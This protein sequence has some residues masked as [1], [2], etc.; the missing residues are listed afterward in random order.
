MENK[1]ISEAGKWLIGVVLAYIVT[2]LLDLIPFGKMFEQTKWEWIVEDRFNIIE[3]IIFTL[4]LI[5]IILVL[6]RIKPAKSKED[7]IEEKLKAHKDFEDPDLG[8]KVTWDM[9]MGSFYDNDPHP[10]N[11]KTYCTKHPMPLLMEYGRCMDNRCPNANANFNERQ[12][13]QFIQSYLL[14]ERDKLMKK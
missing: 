14:N 9:Y 3:M 10:Y 7:A 12:I 2:S 13:E 5:F 6:R 4:S 11:I 1:K 8:L